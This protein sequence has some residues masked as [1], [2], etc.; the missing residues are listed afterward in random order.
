MKPEIE[1]KFLNVNHAELRKKLKSAGGVCE[2]PM[3]LMRRVVMDFPDERLH[4][5]NKGWLRVRDEG[6]QITFTYKE[7]RER[8]A[9]GVRE[10]ETTA[11]DFNTTV[12]LFKSIGLQVYSFQE[13]KRETWYLDGTEVVLDTWPWIKPYIEIEG[14]SEAA[15][16]STAEKLGFDWSDAVFGG[17]TAVYR[18]EYPKI[19]EGETITELPDVKFDAPL[20]QWL[21]DRR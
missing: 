14:P 1:A 16:K 7:Q 5:K 18:S 10:I 9:M 4:L 15:I 17:T 3:R 21:Q 20:P 12:E 6:D 11:G 19:I 8:N 13:S 2:K